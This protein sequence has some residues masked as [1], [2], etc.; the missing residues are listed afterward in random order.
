MQIFQTF[1]VDRPPEAVFDYVADPANLAA[2]QTSKVAVQQLTDGPPRLGTRVRE[3]TKPRVGREFEQ[4]VE[5]TE[6]EPGR[7]LTVHIVDG[8]YPIDGTWTFAPLAS[9][10]RVEARIYGRLSGR[11]RLLEPLLRLALAREF[12][13]YH[14]NLRHNL[15][16][17]DAE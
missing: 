5:F 9:G 11:A 14:A 15:Q 6:F 16:E 2:W 4:I 8:P 10:T 1:P 12:A 7:T 13:A 3:R 17:Q